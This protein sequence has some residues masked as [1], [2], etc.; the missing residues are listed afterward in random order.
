MKKTLFKIISGSF[1][2]QLIGVISVPVLLTAYSIKDVAYYGLFVSICSIG[3][4]FLSFRVENLF[5]SVSD[6]DAKQLNNLVLPMLLC[7]AVISFVSFII[8]DFGDSFAFYGIAVVGSFAIAFFNLS[9]GYGVRIGSTNKYVIARV[10]RNIFEL[11]AVLS[12]VFFHASI[13]F[14]PWMVALSYVLAGMFLSVRFFSASLRGLVSAICILR[15]NINFLKYDFAASIFGTFALNLPVIYFYFL[16]EPVISGLFFSITKLLGVPPLMLAQSVG[17]TLKQHATQEYATTG[18]CDR[19][20]EFV[21][22]NV[23]IK[24]MPLYILLLI[25]VI[26]FSYYWRW[27][28]GDYVFRMVVFLA[29]L[30]F[31]R[32][33]FNCVSSIVYVL[34]FHRHNLLFQITL[35]SLSGVAIF[36]APGSVVGVAMYS[37]VSALLYIVFFG[38]LVRKHIF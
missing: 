31:V 1:A 9:Y 27:G 32:Y 26:L 37:S 24:F 33:I 13:Q 34:G 14:L 35:A 38:W 36:L 20:M 25:L 3:S 5:F 30:F 18:S 22:K 6:S 23:I 4:I 28:E 2:S 12:C 21:V 10:I 8:S 7:G 15:K 19:S 29:P 11:L 17:T 16:N